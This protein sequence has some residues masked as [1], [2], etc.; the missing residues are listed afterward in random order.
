MSAPGSRDLPVLYFNA[1][2]FNRGRN[3]TVR[4][5]RKWHG[6]A[7]ARLQLGDGSL[8]PPVRLQTE[9][10]RFSAITDADLRFEHDPDCRRAG[11]LLLV[12]Q[13]VYPGFSAEEEVTLC[14]FRF[15]EAADDRACP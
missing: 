1:P 7:Q 2:L 11:G 12:L 10:K 13:R 6:V 15:G 3:T 14:H 4:R 8:S 9:L 5:G